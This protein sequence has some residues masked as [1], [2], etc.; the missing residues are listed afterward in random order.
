MNTL[1]VSLHTGISFVAIIILVF[2]GCARKSVSWTYPAS[3]RVSLTIQDADSGKKLNN[4]IM[5]VI[6]SKTDPMK[7]NILQPPSGGIFNA[8]KAEGRIVGDGYVLEQPG[9]QNRQWVGKGE[10]W[11]EY[12]GIEYLFC[13]EGYRHESAEDGLVGSYSR[14]NKPMPI[15]MKKYDPAERH[16]IIGARV[17]AETLSK[18]VQPVYVGDRALLRRSLQIVQAQL[19]AILA[20]DP[21]DKETR[22]ALDDVL[23]AQKAVEGSPVGHAGS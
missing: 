19:E 3:A 11:T 2:L 22:K 5:L 23:S 1:N 20:N 10:L 6:T 8:M 14:V 4:V 12:C 16:S 21:K 13:V 9:V 18:E 7:S 15:E 17:W